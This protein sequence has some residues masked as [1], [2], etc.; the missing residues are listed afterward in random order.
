VAGRRDRPR[1]RL[2]FDEL[3][4]WR[5][6]RALNEL[7]FRTS[8]VGHDD[9]GQPP[10]GSTDEAVL[11][12]A[13]ATRQVVV[14]SNH[15]MVMLCAERGQPVVWIDPY[16]RQFRHDELAVAAF[17]GIAEW[18]RL[19]EA[20]DEAACVHVLRTK[21]EVLPLPQASDLAARRMRALRAR[22][23]RTRPR[24]EAQGGARSA[25]DG[26]DPA[27]NDGTAPPPLQR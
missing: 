19:L 7:G 5:V 11:E 10:R 20:R 24:R 8:H 14:T 13:A 1:I 25:H 22:R 21:V 4:P 23:R 3:L 26:P 12:H 17:R 27:R 2:L 15:D 18:Q 6:A 16:G 9:H